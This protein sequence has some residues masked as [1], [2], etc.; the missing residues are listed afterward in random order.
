MTRQTN[1][2]G[3]LLVTVFLLLSLGNWNKVA[4]TLPQQRLA[5]QPLPVDYLYA[6]EYRTGSMKREDYVLNSMWIR[7]TYYEHP[8]ARD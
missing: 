2:A 3:K 6:R 5:D 1:F 8:S 4:A 7:E